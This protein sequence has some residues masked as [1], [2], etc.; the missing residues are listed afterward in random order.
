VRGPIQLADI[1]RHDVRGQTL[2]SAGVEL[3][4]VR[5]PT[6]RR[7]GDEAL[8]REREDPP[9]LAQTAARAEREPRDASADP[10][11]IGFRRRGRE[12]AMRG[13][14]DANVDRPFFR[15]P[16]ARTAPSW[17]TK[18]LGL[19]RTGH[20][21]DFVEEDG[22]AVAC[23]RS[24]G[25]SRSAPVKAPA[26]RRTTP[27]RRSASGCRAVDRNERTPRTRS[28]VV[29]R[30]CDEFLAASGFAT[31]ERGKRTFA[32]MRISLKP[33]KVGDPIDGSRRAEPWPLRAGQPRARAPTNPQSSE[34]AGS[35]FAASTAKGVRL[36]ST[37]AA[38]FLPSAGS[39]AA[40]A[41]RRASDRT[42]VHPPTR[43]RSGCR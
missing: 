4:G 40:S 26:S 36:S 25:W 24:P 14:N 19:Q 30:A 27:A 22:A 17:S 43:A 28:F 33:K 6:E 11:G 41:A 1:A 10:R 21:A 16:T 8:A 42:E 18:E 34:P 23:L 7:S 13:R 12:I 9:P 32:A 20:V 3:R 5:V 2:V 38:R 15:A 39:G 31:D 35:R 37:I 29:E